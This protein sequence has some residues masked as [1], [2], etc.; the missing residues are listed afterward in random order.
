MSARLR[1]LI[2]LLAILVFLALYIS[3]AVLIADRLPDNQLVRFVYFAGVG[4]LWGV[5]LFPLLAWMNRGR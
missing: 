4:L 5:P 3:A 2:G 1:K